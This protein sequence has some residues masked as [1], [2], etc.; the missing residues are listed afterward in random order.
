MKKILLVDDDENVRMSFKCSLESIGHAVVVAKDGKEAIALYRKERP[1]VVLM[2][3]LMP[4][5]D[6]VEATERIRCEFP[7]AK[8][9]AMSGGWIR[10]KEFFL[11]EALSS[12]ADESIE[13]P[14]KAEELNNLI[15]KVL[16]SD[17][18]GKDSDCCS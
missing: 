7:D 10:Q 11:N 8:I 12:G 13:K 2:D 17:C 5:M 6:G 16:K 4:R 1:H 18:G 15:T 3:V 9:I 14:C